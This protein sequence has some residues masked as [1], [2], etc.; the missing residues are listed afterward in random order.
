MKVMS[1]MILKDEYYQ[2]KADEK[3]DVPSI[4]MVGV[5]RSKDC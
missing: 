3:E 1:K 2:A 4:S 5:S